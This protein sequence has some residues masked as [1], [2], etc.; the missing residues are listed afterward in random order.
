MNDVLAKL[1]ITRLQDY[2]RNIEKD[3]SFGKTE[4]AS[5]MRLE[6][7][8]L[9]KTFFLPYHS[10][11]FN[12]KISLVMKKNIP[13]LYYITSE[14]KPI[15]SKVTGEIN[16]KFREK[17]T[18]E[19]KGEQV[20]FSH[21]KCESV[22]NP[23][24]KMV[25]D[26]ENPV[27]K[28]LGRL[29]YKRIKDSHGHIRTV[30]RRSNANLIIYT[31]TLISMLDYL[32]NTKA[33]YLYSSMQPCMFRSVGKDGKTPQYSVPLID[34]EKYL[35]TT[36]SMDHSKTKNEDEKTK[37]NDLSIDFRAQNSFDE[38]LNREIDNAGYTNAVFSIIL[39][40]LFAVSGGGTKE[41]KTHAVSALAGCIKRASRHLL[42]I[43]FK[44]GDD[45]Y[46]ILLRKKDILQAIGTARR[47]TA[48]VKK[49]AGFKES[50]YRLSAGVIQ[51]RPN[52]K[53]DK[54]KKFINKV[55]LV[56]KKQKVPRI[57][58]IDRD[59]ETLKAYKLG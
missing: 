44:F 57:I 7:Q 32:I 12:R 45:E 23:W 18:R 14:M 4:V 36:V 26:L 50:T 33:S 41:T 22:K 52:W 5:K 19:L 40:H 25:F 42:D 48:E 6:L 2:C 9:K 38:E 8:H 51:Y 3:G 10:F 27:S 28:R 17:R 54:C 39:L 37:Q 43:P 20:K 15:L 11:Q 21:L 16:D 30:D 34:S 1:Y 53:F 13:K 59:S 31:H 49:N 55:R 35:K 47:I 46:L 24:R 29:L 56:I 58:F